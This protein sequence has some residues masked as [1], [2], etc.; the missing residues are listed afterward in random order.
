MEAHV[1]RG[2]MGD[3][4]RARVEATGERVA[5]K[6]MR[7]ASSSP[8][9]DAATRER[10]A[11][12]SRLLARLVHP[13]IVPYVAHGATA[14]GR[15]FVASRWL[16]GPTL[17]ERLSSSRLSLHDARA[18][19]V[20]VAR[21]LAAAHAASVVHRDVKPA[22][23][24]L[25][26]DGEPILI[27]F[28]VAKSPGSAVTRDGAIVGTHGYMSP[29]QLRGGSDVGAPSDVY[30]LGCVLFR[31]L[32]GVTP[33]E[34]ASE[35]ERLARVLRGEVPDVRKRRADVPH[36]LADLLA[37]M[38]SVDAA[39]RPSAN[40]VEERLRAIDLPDHADA[41]GDALSRSEQA[42]VSVVV[43]AA[44]SPDAP[45]TK[46]DPVTGEAAHALRALFEARGGRVEVLQN[47]ACV[48]VF[49]P[50]A[51]LGEQVHDAASLA[52]E[53]R[54][55]A[56]DRPVALVT[57]RA[58]ITGASTSSEAVARALS[59]VRGGEAATVT[60]DDASASLLASRFVV[61]LRDGH[62]VLR[63]ER[64][65]PEASR[66]VHGRVI[67]MFGRDAELAQVVA[68]A[69]VPHG[70]AALVVG[71]SGSGKTRLAAEVVL[72]I[73]AERDDVAVVVARADA[74][75]SG[76]PFAVARPIARLL[77]SPRIAS[78]SPEAA[79]FAAFLATDTWDED[80][81]HVRA[82]RVDPTL[83]R[84]R[85]RSAFTDLV[86]RAIASRPVL[87][88][89]EDAQWADA[90]SLEALAEAVRAA[91][92]PFFV[93]AL[94][95]PEILD[96]GPP[97]GERWATV[98]LG[99]LDDDA[100]AALARAIVGDESADVA[101]I[102]RLG[103]GHAFFVEE[104]AR[105]AAAGTRTPLPG[106]V[107][108]L[109]QA[110]LAALTAHARQVLR[111]ASLLRPRITRGGLADLLGT[112][113]G[114]E[115][116]D[117]TLDDLVAREIL[118]H[119]E[120]AFLFRHELL[121]EA[122]YAGL[123]EEDARRGHL[124]VAKLFEREGADPTRIAEH[125]ERGGDR[126]AAAEAHVRAAEAAVLGDDLKSALASA[127]RADA[128]GAADA[129]RGRALAV[130]AAVERW[131]GDV[132]GA[133]E[134]GLEALAL[135]DPASEHAQRTAA[136]V[137]AA[138]GSAGDEAALDAVAAHLEGARGGASV[139]RIRA[140][141]SAALSLSR[142]GRHTRADAVLARAEEMRREL[143]ADHAIADVGLL[144]A[145]AAQRTYAGDPD[146]YRAIMPLLV[147]GARR[148][149]DPRTACLAQAHLGYGWAALGVWDE[150]ERALLAAL[151]EA[152]RL[153]LPLA[154]AS[155]LHN[156]AL[157]FE[158]RGE[159]DR[160][161]QT[162]KDA[163]VTSLEQR[164][165]R[166]VTACRLYIAQNRMLAG[167]HR[168]AVE[169]ARLA[170]ERANEAPLRASALAI[171]AQALVGADDARASVPLARE[172]LA[173]A[174]RIGGVGEEEAAV[175]R[176][177]PLALFAVGE[178]EEG[179][180]AL[181]DAHD[182]LVVRARMIPDARH[183]ATFLEGVRENAATMALCR[184]HGIV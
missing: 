135:L 166:L 67:P 54:A 7:A 128:C 53:A 19:G 51:G 125:F 126:A 55:L 38:L 140:L 39:Q 150:A 182:R 89:L 24:V 100:A 44:T 41:P 163:L 15:P 77:D 37:S 103:D 181:V 137:A 61:E 172:A 36:L 152:E 108:A 10:F 161:L 146:A 117:A 175:R 153:A 158:T 94:A 59:L 66:V 81:A 114:S 132:A 12:E 73:R 9:D 64:S 160:A 62:H 177:L 118:V 86:R 139:W 144:A 115:N 85:L 49:G 155:A 48:G 88:V 68:L 171:L 76:A 56:G 134:L 106:S 93:L 133:A 14:D 151:E 84:D 156:L 70:G 57:G 136:D 116:F 142:A 79:P 17:A 162:Q 95:R 63:A 107:V 173:L 11:R 43:V 148:I 174:L 96:G 21:A 180:A 120:D 13:N 28:G 46:D 74:M 157:V 80:D 138:A 111:A 83:M 30:G 6:V 2:G 165:A 16:D 159:I 1:A 145:R 18:I 104:L 69:R 167:D 8:D 99:P 170:C 26:K 50:R 112:S 98:E 58:E 143:A 164:N 27:D 147:D 32:T 184:A 131:Q 154:R 75:R 105:A 25:V 101:S 179:R 87:L 92:R 45:T 123:T 65:A 35:S 141:A 72:R 97:F 40:E 149:G 22:N 127:L 42:L 33:F 130:R 122:A 91:T 168:E 124:A 31:A 183:R 178:I 129:L 82:A 34:G 23:I 4:Y 5:L 60:T 109:T 52:L 102:V 169:Q 121:A 78:A 119:A 90:P 20:A 3:V 29:E 47:G 71:P 176:A 113:A 110:R